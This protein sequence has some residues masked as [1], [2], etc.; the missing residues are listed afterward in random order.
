M[1]LNFASETTSE[2]NEIQ[3]NLKYNLKVND[4]TFAVINHAVLKYQPLI[5]RFQDEAQ[6][7]NK[8]T[9]MGNQFQL[10]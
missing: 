10:D 5:K 3:N 2:S 1:S 7:L 8:I 4:F 9:Q 6:E